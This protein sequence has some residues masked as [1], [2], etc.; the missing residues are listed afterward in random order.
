VRSG[1][2]LM[3]YYCYLVKLFWPTNLAVFYPHPGRWPMEQVL[4]AGVLL[5]GISVL[6]ILKGR[7]YPCLLMGW[8]WYCGTLV[9]VIGLVQV[10]DQAMA[11]RY[12]YVPSLGVLIL[13]IWGGCEL[14]R[15]RRYHVIALSVAGSAGIVLC[16]ASTREQIGYWK[17]SEALFRHALDVTE[18]NYVAHSSL[19]GALLKK[20]QT[21]EAI[22]QYQ[23]ALRLQPDKATSHNNL[24]A[25]LLKKDHTSEAISQLQEAI[26]LNP[27]Y[28][29]AHGNLGAALVNKGQTE[30]AIRQFQEV[31]RLQPDV[32]ASHNNLGAALEKKGQIGEAISQ[33]QEAIRLEPSSLNARNNLGV[34]LL[35]KGRTDEAISQFREVIRLKPDYA[36]VH[37]N[38]GAALRMKGQIDEAI[39][40]YQE[41]LRLRP[42][43]AEAHNKLGA[44]F[45]SKGQIDEAI[46]QFQEAIRLKPDDAEVHNNLGV[47]FGR[48]GQIDE[49]IS[50]FEEALRLKPDYADACN[51]LG[52][53]WAERGENLEQ[54]RAM[55]EKAVKLEPKK[56]AFLDTLSW[57]VFKLNRPREA[58]DYELQA[59]E[60][61]GRPDAALYDHLG[62]IYAA[63]NQREQAAEAWRKSLAV[64][65]SRQIEKKLGDLSAH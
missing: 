55:I 7:K 32:A 24:G 60:K 3:S 20:G 23:E 5:C 47:A 49:A 10:G 30:E 39:S 19:G 22:S 45:L 48:K 2:A 11:D 8:L 46:S 54:A 18:N 21:D 42:D 36:E 27:D 13:A 4:L 64:E 6:L 50:Q 9:P 12:T 33:F 59:V 41:A 25:A 51:N 37:Y 26:R 31:L 52:Y 29:D 63:L 58:L 1:N 34:G 16:F 62:D 61:S 65:P 15:R 38:L 43:Y 57:V 28:A 56:A 53:R 17:D 35:N 40:Q 44:G 14:I